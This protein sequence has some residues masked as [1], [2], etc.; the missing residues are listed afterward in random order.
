[1]L[2]LKKKSEEIIHTFS[3]IIDLFTT[4]ISPPRHMGTDRIRYLYEMWLQRKQKSN[5][6][7]DKFWKMSSNHIPRI[8]YYLDPWQLHHLSVSRK[9][10]SLDPRDPRLK[11]SNTYVCPSYGDV[12]P[13]SLDKFYVRKLGSLQKVGAEI[14]NCP[15]WIF[16]NLI[17]LLYTFF[18]YVKLVF[19]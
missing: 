14:F 5:R 11:I 10:Q 6:T 17:V 19:H 8:F 16:C 3:R 15:I 13:F 1:M 4:Y 7:E 12:P 18:P 9:T 2:F